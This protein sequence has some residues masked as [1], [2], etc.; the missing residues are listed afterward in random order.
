LA[1]GPPELTEANVR[2]MIENRRRRFNAEAAPE[3]EAYPEPED[4]PVAAAAAGGGA[5]AAAAAAP[6][7]EGYDPKIHYNPEYAHLSKK[8]QIAKYHESLGNL[9]NQREAMGLRRW[10]INRKPLRPNAPNF[11]PKGGKR[12]QM[13]LQMHNQ[14]KKTRKLRKTRKQRKQS[15]KRQG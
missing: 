4:E 12:L 6:I 13:H 14:K 11:V 15:K 9:R 7:N 2:R 3:D 5:A 10:P 1:M 8:E